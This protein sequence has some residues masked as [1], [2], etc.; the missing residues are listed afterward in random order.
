M[1][2]GVHLLIFQ[3]TGGKTTN[4]PSIQLTMLTWQW[5]QSLTWQTMTRHPVSNP[6]SISICR[7]SQFPSST[8]HHD[9]TQNHARD[10]LRPTT[11][12]THQRFHLH[13]TP[14]HLPKTPPNPIIPQHRFRGPPPLAS[15]NSLPPPPTLVLRPIQP[16]DS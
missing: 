4:Y 16:L 14:I 12:Q 3:T 1:M 7:S 2:K 8:N 9:R 13:N 11:Q 5:T 6:L 15:P 10:P